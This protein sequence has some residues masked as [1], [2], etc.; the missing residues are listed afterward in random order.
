MPLPCVL[1]DPRPKWQLCQFPHNPHRLHAD[2]HHPLDQIDNVAFVVTVTIRITRDSAAL[3]GADLIL[4][5]HP[6]QRAAV[7]QPWSAPCCC[8]CKP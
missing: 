2:A 6:L 4:V 8:S 3:I 7:A 5:D 1:F